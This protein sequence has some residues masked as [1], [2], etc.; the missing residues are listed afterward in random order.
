MLRRCGHGR[1]LFMG[2][3]GRD[4]LVIL[5]DTDP[6]SRA[7]ALLTERERD[8]YDLLLA[9]WSTTQIAKSLHIDAGTVRSHVAHIHHK[10]CRSHL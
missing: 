2:G 6:L 8:I 10:L 7:V 3:R 9:G 1:R 5:T 4:D